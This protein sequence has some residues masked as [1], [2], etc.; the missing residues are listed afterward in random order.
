MRLGQNIAKLVWGRPHTKAEI[1][2][3]IAGVENYLVVHRYD[4]VNAVVLA[5]LLVAAFSSVGLVVESLIWGAAVIVAET[6]FTLIRHR[7]AKERTHGRNVYRRITT[8]QVVSVGTMCLW[9]FGL[10]FAYGHDPISQMIVTLAWAG[11]M[12]VVT[13]QNGAIPRVSLSSAALPALMIAVVPLAVASHPA[14]YALAGL[15]ISLVVLV[16]Y[17]TTANL[18]TNR[19]LFEAQADKDELIG[20]LQIA[21]QAVDADRRR[22]E[23]ASRAKSEFL[24][25][26]S[27]E[28]RTPMNGVLGM[29]QMLARSDLTEEQQAYAETIVESGDALL[30][31]LNDALDL[32]RIEAGRMTLDL[33]EDSPH[34]VVQAVRDLW[35]P[36]AKDQGLSFDLE[37]A[38]DLPVRVETDA[39]KLRQV[40]SNLVGNAIKFTAQGGVTLAASSP[41]KGILRFEVRDTGPGIPEDAQARIFER[42]TQADTSTTRRFGGSGLGL[43]ICKQIVELMQ[44]AISVTS[45]EGEGARF[46]VELPVRVLAESPAE[47]VLGAPEEVFGGDGPLRILVAEDHPTNQKLMRAILKELGHI[48]EFVENGRQAVDAVAYGAFDLVLMD[49]QMPV[50]D[51]VAATREIRDMPNERRA[52]PIVALTA[53][54]A[55]GQREEYLSLGFDDYVAKPFEPAQ[56]CRAIEKAAGRAPAADSFAPRAA[57]A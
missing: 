20:E 34:R 21:R 29:A 19:K 1:D 16:A 43:T 31:L 2:E 54:A 52:I 46:I 33:D 18:E 53:N 23:E 8:L 55:S 17:N 49:V 14:E 57:S 22:A 32:S 37:V 9:S 35:A 15:S 11:A 13:N 40:L 42:F 44:G 41:R 56:L 26:M 47:D 7:M 12:V 36:R 24:A 50:L 25:I 45:R 10:L 4:L 5:A 27:H 39:R 28:I 51:G 38:D 3:A 48:G 30:S 6:G